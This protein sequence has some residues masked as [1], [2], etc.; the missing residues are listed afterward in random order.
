MVFG[1]DSFTLR[2]PTKQNL[3][4]IWK[5]G[6]SSW[7]SGMVLTGQNLSVRRVCGYSDS[8]LQTS[9]CPQ[10][11]TLQ[12]SLEGILLW[13][14]ISFDLLLNCSIIQQLCVFFHQCS[15]ALPLLVALLRKSP[16]ITSNDAP[17][18]FSRSWPTTSSKKH[19]EDR[20]SA[21]KL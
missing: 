19:P 9:L 13:L 20:I 1:C 21:R 5:K 6:S 2:F 15:L 12:H 16:Q 7:G 11:P 10:M 14:A 4:R 17:S 3:Q 18:D 8:W